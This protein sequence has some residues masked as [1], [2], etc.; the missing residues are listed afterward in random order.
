MYA[1]NHTFP[2][3]LETELDSINLCY[4]RRPFCFS[5]N[6]LGTLGNDTILSFPEQGKVAIN[7]LVHIFILLRNTF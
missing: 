5:K 2:E 4:C 3:H 7:L 6:T 1:V